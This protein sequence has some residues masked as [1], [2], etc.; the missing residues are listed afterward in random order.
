ML[1]GT[2]L[3][4]F[5]SI[6]EPL[7]FQ[8]AKQHH[9]VYKPHHGQDQKVNLLP[10]PIFQTV[11][12][13]IPGIISQSAYSLIRFG[14]LRHRT[15]SQ[16]SLLIAASCGNAGVT[17]FRALFL[18]SFLT[19]SSIMSTLQTGVAAWNCLSSQKYSRSKA[20]LSAVSPNECV[21]KSSLVVLK[22]EKHLTVKP[23]RVQF[24]YENGL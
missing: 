21:S 2:T 20:A 12:T 4:T 24:Q 14:Y 19:E 17:Y 5:V 8:V 3:S 23:Q 13:V 15:P 22:T 6:G 18:A 11:N 10:K 1:E 16:L 9:K 7:T